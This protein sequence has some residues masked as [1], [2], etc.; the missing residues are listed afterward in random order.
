MN[1]A[2]YEQAERRGSEQPWVRCNPDDVARLGLAD[3][4]SRGAH[5]RLR[6]HGGMLRVDK[7]MRSGV[8]SMTHG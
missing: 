6:H 2:R 8:V 7:R 3:G 4:D 5:E 1:S